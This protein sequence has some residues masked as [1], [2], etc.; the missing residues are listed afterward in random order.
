MFQIYYNYSIINCKA[1]I[2][3]TELMINAIDNI[4]TS[5]IKSYN[6]WTKGKLYHDIDMNNY[7]IRKYYKKINNFIIIKFNLYNKN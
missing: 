3:G 7:Y 4:S 5:T 6:Q 2:V 1:I